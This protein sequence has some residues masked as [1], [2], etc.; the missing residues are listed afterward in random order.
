[1]RERVSCE[2]LLIR[3][4]PDPVNGEFVNV[5]VLLRE[6]QAGRTSVRF[7]RNWK[8][9]RCLDPDADITLLEALEGELAVRLNVIDHERRDLLEVLRSSC[10]NA[11]QLTEPRASLAESLPAE[12]ERLM[13]LYV[14]P[15]KTARMQVSGRAGLARAMRLAFERAGVWELMR[16]GIRAAEYTGA[17]D[18]LR[19]DCGYRPNGVV[20]MFQAV[21]LAGEGDG[22]KVLAFS[23]ERLRA[24]VLRKEEAE[25]ELTAIVE[26][27]NRA[28]EATEQDERYRF[29][30]MA[31]EQ[32]AIRVM[33][34]NDL[35]RAAETARRELGV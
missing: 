15:P 31:M 12:M 11:V 22:A 20:R 6:V 4:L 24:G 17:G 21:S 1:M 28:E 7:T 33:T 23:A 16:K 14:T 3:Y 34:I 13:K 5:G 26:P 30:V 29:G 35:G 8:R 10:S 19:L 9:V 25:L 27:L 32:A 18:T 2:F